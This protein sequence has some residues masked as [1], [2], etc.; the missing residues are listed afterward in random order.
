[1]T[2]NTI[3]TDSKP[4]ADKK[5]NTPIRHTFRWVLILAAL[6]F[7]VNGHLLLRANQL[8]KGG[9]FFGLAI[10]LFVALFWRLAGF[11]HGLV[12]EP[13]ARRSFNFSGSFTGRIMLG[14][15]ILFAGLSFWLF[16]EDLPPYYPWLLYWLSMFLLI[17]SSFWTNHIKSATQRAAPFA[18]IAKWKWLEVVIFL[19]ILA[20]AAFM[21]L[22]RFD[23]IPFG[24][25]FDEAD[26]GLSA[27][28]ILDSPEY[29]PVFVKSTNLPA[30]FLYLIAFSFQN[31]G[32]SIFSL[33]MV[34]V[35]FGMAT[36]AAAFFA[37]AEL[38]N[39]RKP[40]LLLAFFLAVSRWDVN[41]SRIGMHAVTVPFFELLSVGL[42]LR[43]LRTQNLL[44]YTFAGLSLGMGLCFYTPLFLFPTVIA[45]FLLFLWLNRHDLLAAH[46]RG[47]LFLALGFLIASIPISQF[48]VRD[49]ETFTSRMQITSIFTDKTPQ[50]GWRA[51]ARTAR[52]HILM[53]NQHGDNNGR[54]NL[55]GEPMLDPVSGAF[56]VL[57]LAL[58]LRRIRQP[59]SFLL[60]AWF[61]IMLLPGI[62]SLDFESPQS[63]RAIGTLPPAYILAVIPILAMWQEWQQFVTRYSAVLF[64]LPLILVLGAMGY[65][66]YHTYFDLQSRRSDVWGVFSTA[67][68]LIGKTMAAL[69]AN[70][71]VYLSVFYHNSTTMQFI[72]PN[73][74]DYHALQT[75]DSLP[76]L[77]EGTRP[78]VFFVDRD[79][80][81]FFL[82]AQKYYPNA[83][84]KEYKAPDG[85]V[86]F[87]QIILQPSDIHAAQGITASYY[88]NAEQTGEPFLVKTEKTIHQNWQDGSPAAFPFWVK[89]QGVL[90]A[91]TYQTY[92]FILHS[93]SAAQ[94]YVDGAPIPLAREGDV[95]QTAEVELAKGSHALL[96]TAEGKPGLFQLDWQPAQSSQTLIPA[97]H[98]FLPPISNNGL[99]GYYFPNGDWQAPAAL[100]QIDPWL[101]FYY[102]NQP[103][104]RPY[105]VEWVGR[106]KIPESGDYLFLLKSLSESMLFIDNRQVIGVGENREANIY[107]SQGFHP[108]RLRYADRTFYTYINFEWMPPNGNL[109]VV[110][111][112]ALFLP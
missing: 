51:V 50:E 4:Q 16:G 69:G 15:A 93:P 84:F 80:E 112:E 32:V 45:V 47:F 109:D 91:E 101:R 38:F 110:P 83:D 3:L 26:N 8:A 77:F 75:Y 2:Q 66:N 108:I 82:Q 27:L 24:L 49:F 52:D 59:A 85:T 21:R 90:F 29:L 98:F 35:I 87:Y 43:A 73:F 89:W 111:Q 6:A 23:E 7:A 102:Q 18:N 41:W 105:S 36:V 44:N 10:V 31:L 68:T 96:L 33:R 97:S 48:A 55:P 74:R 61:F 72:A 22:Y 56:M 103:L 62:F 13:W 5:T 37:G 30:H 88:R 64:S 9:I 78:V 71:D 39:N 70:A 12:E 14:F 60:V 40:A 20:I 65:N 76:M 106:I 81:P 1:M 100:I 58:S 94:L 34:S 54:H 79:R 25:W 46:W 67:E 19:L 28:A 104:E 53:F 92:R 17:S 57:G 107:L 42:V 95:A 11:G 99:L 86:I 63:L